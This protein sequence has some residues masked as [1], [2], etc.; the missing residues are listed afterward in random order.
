EDGERK[1]VSRA[2]QAAYAAQAM[3]IAKNRPRIDMFVWFVFRDHSTSLWQSG[4]LNRSGGAKPALAR[5]RSLAA[6]LNA[7]N[8]VV[9]VR[10]GVANPAVVVPLREYGAGTAA[11]EQVGFNY[12]VFWRGAF[13]H[14]GQPS[15]PFGTDANARIVLDGFRPVKGRTYAVHVE[16]N[17]YSGG[18]VILRRV[19]TL[20]AT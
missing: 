19:L 14:S 20:N 6:G 1:G 8:A 15:A 9:N 3:T 5:F 13:V 12:K 16:A 17:V 18:G 10:G 4:L 7:R 11:G 2:Q